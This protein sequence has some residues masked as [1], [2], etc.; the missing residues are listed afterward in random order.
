[1]AKEEN[2]AIENET[3]AAFAYDYSSN[4]DKKLFI[5]PNESRLKNKLFD[6]LIM[7]GSDDDPNQTKQ[8]LTALDMLA[9]K[10]YAALSEEKDQHDLGGGDDKKYTLREDYF[11]LYEEWADAKE[12][13]SEAQNSKKEE[14]RKIYPDTDAQSNEKFNNAYH[15]W[16]ETAAKSNQNAISRISKMMLNDISLFSL[17]DM[18]CFESI[19]DSSSAAWLKQMC[20]S[21]NNTRK[22]IPNGVYVYP[23]RVTP[24][25]WFEL[26]ETPFTPIDLLSSQLQSLSLRRMD[27]CGRIADIS[28]MI[29]D[30]SSIEAA[31]TK[32]S[33]AKEKLDNVRNDIIENYGDG[34]RDLLVIVFDIVPEFSEGTVL[35][36]LSQDFLPI[37][38]FP[39]VK[40]W[41][42]SL[43]I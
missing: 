20:S 38:P 31:Q 34:I 32:V 42:V 27:L 24:D 4:A 11:R 17:D 16:Y 12:K 23:V 14:L 36:T 41:Q 15:E 26:L 39:M 10:L 2:K 40:T 1:M 25:N 18:N 5:S 43:M 30:R 9:P 13:W 21:L 28:A 29:P 33:K 37:L 22:P 8:L 3:A 6:R 7:I 35:Q 19:L